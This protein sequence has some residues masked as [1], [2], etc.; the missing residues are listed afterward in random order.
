M[1]DDNHEQRGRGRF[2]DGG[3]V[4]G[5]AC[6]RDETVGVEFVAKGEGEQTRAYGFSV[7]FASFVA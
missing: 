7:G 3:V 2:P 6:S 5:E 4:V 1:S